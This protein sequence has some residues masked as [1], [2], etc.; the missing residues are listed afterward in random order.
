MNKY[1]KLKFIFDIFCVKKI[2]PF[3]LVNK[4]HYLGYMPIKNTVPKIHILITVLQCLQTRRY[5]DI[6][7]KYFALLNI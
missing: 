3:F 5:L 1:P 7:K 2:K 6:Q 4:V